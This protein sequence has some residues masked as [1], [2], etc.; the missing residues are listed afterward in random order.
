MATFTPDAPDD[1][2]ARRPAS[3]VPRGSGGG[4]ASLEQRLTTYLCYAQI[5]GDALTFHDLL[6]RC[7]SEHVEQVRSALGALV[8]AGRVAAGGG[9]YCLPDGS[10]DQH[11][12]RREERG[13]LAERILGENR[14]LLALLTRLPF[15]RLVAV[16]GSVAAANPVRADGNGPD[17][18]LFIITA[19]GSLHIVRFAL[20]VLMKLGDLLPRLGLTSRA[21]RV[22]P[23]FMVE[24]TASEIENQSLYTATESVQMRV[25]TG[26]DAYRGFLRRNSWIRRY[27][28]H[29]RPADGAAD[30]EANGKAPAAARLVRTTLNLVCFAALGAGS[31]LK[32]R[33]Y[34]TGFSYSIQ[35]DLGKEKSL[36]RY[37]PVGG[38]YQARIRA[39]FA[40][41]Y[42]AHFGHLCSDEYLEFLFPHTSEAGIWLNGRLFAPSPKLSLS[43]Y[44]GLLSA[45]R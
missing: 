18:D 13:R 2:A 17:C 28:A 45:G 42:R 41:L 39:R 8:A 30:H 20:R 23:N 36:R 26:D 11:A 43:H 40:A 31:W 16:S 7:G 4:F 33:L 32:H 37:R 12:T 5:F 35:P 29:T 14:R 6:L 10:P 44:D 15:V 9:F 25:L 24:E 27:Y 38:G 3:A 22:C 34:G 1:S 19:D 21:Y